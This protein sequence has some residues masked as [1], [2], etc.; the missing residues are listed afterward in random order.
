MNSIKL[1]AIAFLYLDIEQTQFGMIVVQHPFT[2]SGM[3]CLP[4]SEGHEFVNL[5]EDDNAL[6]RW[7]DFMK[8]QIEKRKNVYQPY[9]MI[10]KL[11][12]VAFL[13]HCRF[14]VKG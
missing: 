14:Y 8:E 4:N 3:V 1:T 7:R 9:L 10:N 12:R 13:I 11:Y 6:K 5:L 2:N